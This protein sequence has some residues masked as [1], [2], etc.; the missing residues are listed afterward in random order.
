MQPARTKLE[1]TTCLPD[2]GKLHWSSGLTK[3]GYTP[4][5]EVTE[6]LK[7]WG[8]EEFIPRAIKKLYHRQLAEPK[9]E[10]EEQTENINPIQDRLFFKLG[11]MGGAIW[12]TG[13][14]D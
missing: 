1:L 8:T 6:S 4:P 11:R 3:W 2:G 12:P 7:D 9:K 10:G 5:K 13:L 14:F